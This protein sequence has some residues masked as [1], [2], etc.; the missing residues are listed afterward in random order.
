M[1]K[2]KTRKWHN[3]DSVNNLTKCTW[4]SQLALQLSSI[5]SYW[6]HYINFKIFL[7]VE[8]TNVA[9][10]DTLWVNITLANA[11]SPVFEKHNRMRENVLFASILFSCGT[12]VWGWTCKS[13][14]LDTFFLQCYF[15]VI[16]TCCH[17]LSLFDWQSSHRGHLQV[18]SVRLRYCYISTELSAT[19]S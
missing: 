17:Y 2:K 4:S 19:S 7:N 6:M 9:Q 5:P 16:S 14:I 12:Y 13:L 8:C 18:N 15:I 3:C 10:S 1:A 11:M